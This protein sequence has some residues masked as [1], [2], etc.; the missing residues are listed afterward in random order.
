MFVYLPLVGE[1]RDNDEKNEGAR[2]C[3]L[4][5]QLCRYACQRRR[6]RFTHLA[7]SIPVR[8]GSAY[9]N[10]RTKTLTPV[11]VSFSLVAVTRAPKFSI[12]VFKAARF[13][14]R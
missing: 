11:P 5:E 1:N 8:Q 9:R 7:W 2:G 13:H 14:V 6:H 3:E 10:K 12:F 4:H